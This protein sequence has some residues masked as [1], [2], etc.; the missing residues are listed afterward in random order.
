MAFV[1]SSLEAQE[2]YSH[3]IGLGLS[4]VL[5]EA[6]QMAPAS[7]GMQAVQSFCWR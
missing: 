5:C 2:L 6:I 4:S 3:L 1:V 7:F